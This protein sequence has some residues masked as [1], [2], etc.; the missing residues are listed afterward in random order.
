MKCMI[1]WL[2]LPNTIQSATWLTHAPLS[3]VHS[4]FLHPHIANTTSHPPAHHGSAPWSRP[5]TGLPSRRQ[6]LHCRPEPGS[7]ANGPPVAAL[8]RW[9]AGWGVR[10]HRAARPYYLELL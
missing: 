3:H 1:V 4:G 6:R 5:E 2:V 9:Q 10:R 7:A 8:I